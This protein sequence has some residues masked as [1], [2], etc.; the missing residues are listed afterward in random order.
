VRLLEFIFFLATPLLAGLAIVAWLWAW[1]WHAPRIGPVCA[2]W[3]AGGTLFFVAWFLTGLSLTVQSSF[4]PWLMAG[5]AVT[6]FIA[7]LYRL[8]YHRK[9][10]ELGSST[11]VADSYL[12]KLFMGRH[13]A[14]AETRG[15]SHRSGAS[16]AL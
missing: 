3:C 8:S 6:A 11:R 14:V 2:A 1:H 9:Q 7:L 13:E 15:Q 10:T 16:I 5:C 12:Q 4:L